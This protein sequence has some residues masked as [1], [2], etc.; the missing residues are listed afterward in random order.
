[1]HTQEGIK[2][3]FVQDLAAVAEKL[4]KNPPKELEGRVSYLVFTD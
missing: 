1:M 2:E 3:R 4:V